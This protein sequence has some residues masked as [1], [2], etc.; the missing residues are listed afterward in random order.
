MRRLFVSAFQVLCLIGVMVFG[1]SAQPVEPG[2]EG[3]LG[4]LLAPQPGNHICFARS[5]SADHL[6][7]HPRQTVT[8][9]QFRLAYY[10]HDP[11]KYAPQGQRNYYFA[12][13][14]KRRGSSKTL[15]SLGECTASGERISCN[16]E[17]DGGGVKVRHRPDNKLLVYFENAESY[18]RLTEGCDEEE[19]TVELKPGSDDKEF[20]LTQTASCPAYDDW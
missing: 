1:A 6:K 7:A 11:D 16:V 14:A 5:Y 19:D 8:D 12:L 17:C 13:I 3:E 20:L 15:T 10:R 9:L 18:I 2:K 4:K